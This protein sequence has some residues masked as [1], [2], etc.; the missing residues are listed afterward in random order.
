MEQQNTP[1]TRFEGPILYSRQ[2]NRFF[3]LR[4]MH[5]DYVVCGGFT[6]F[7]GAA[8]RYP[9]AQQLSHEYVASCEYV[10]ALDKADYAEL[11]DQ[12]WKVIEREGGGQ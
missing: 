1:P 10:G 9:T 5:D 4:G 12:G 3:Q 11:V 2:C 6:V 7:F 8:A